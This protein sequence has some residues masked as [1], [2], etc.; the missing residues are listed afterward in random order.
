MEKYPFL[1][2]WKIINLK[3]EFLVM[4]HAFFTS[5]YLARN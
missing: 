2:I 3:M 5:Y 1:G 4:L